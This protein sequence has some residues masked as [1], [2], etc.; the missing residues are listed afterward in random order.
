[1]STLGASHNHKGSR[2]PQEAVCQR[3]PPPLLGWL[4]SSLAFLEGSRDSGQPCTHCSSA[5]VMKGPL[6]LQME[7]MCRPGC[8]GRAW[9]SLSPN[10]HEF[11]SPDAPQTPHF[12]MFQKL[13]HVDMIDRSVTRRRRGWAESGKLLIRFR[14]P[15]DRDPPPESPPVTQE[16]PSDSGAQ[17]QDRS[18]RPNIRTQDAAR[19][20][21]TGGCA[22]SPAGARRGWWRGC[23][24]ARG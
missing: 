18:Q 19:A 5:L 22:G 10:F 24:A 23:H 17:G 8:V 7:A 13:H 2:E 16:I 21:L 6:L 15:G 9:H 20:L 12:R 1:M 11:P 14:L 3:C 4:L